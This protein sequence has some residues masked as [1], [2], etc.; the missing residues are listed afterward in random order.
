M[1]D[2]TTD[3]AVKAFLGKFDSDKEA[4]EVYGKLLDQYKQELKTISTIKSDEA[5]QRRAS[6][7]KDISNIQKSL[8]RL[9]KG[10]AVAGGLVAGGIDL[11]A[12]PG[13]IAVSAANFLADMNIPIPSEVAKREI[14]QEGLFFGN[15]QLP[16][17]RAETAETRPFFGFSRGAVQLPMRTPLGT[18]AQSA[19]Y[20][21]AGAADESGTATA[22]LGAGQVLAGIVQ[23][24]RGGITAY[25]ARQLVKDLPPNERNLL[26]NFMLR[27]QSGSDPQT[28]A[29]IQRLKAN[30]ET[31]E[32]MNA[33]EQGAKSI[34]LAGMAPIATEGKIA[35][36]AYNAI[37]QKLRTLQY[38]ISGKPISD[39]FERAKNIL[40]DS[41]SVPILTTLSRID[42]LIADFANKGTDSSKAA[43]AAL[44]R[45]KQS[46]MTPSTVGPA[47]P[48]TTVEK[49][50]G[51]LSS[52]GAK[53]AGE[54]N[55]LKDVARSD[56]ERIAAVI[57]GGLKTDLATA[58][59]STNLDVRKAA[60]TLEDARKS[61]EKGYTAY[62]NFVAQGLPEKLRN[63]DL[64]QL[65]DVEFTKVF[66]G[67]TTDQRNRILPILEAQAP[68]AVDR[69]RLSYYNNFLQG[70][71]K[72]LPDGTFGIDF[73]KLVAKYNTLKPEDRELLSFSL[74][75]N[76]K[77]FAERMDDATKFFRYNMRIRAVPEEGQV[78]TGEQ[79]AK[80][81]AA[82]GAVTDYATAKAADVGLRLFNDL[83][84]NLKDTDVLR[85]LLTNEGKQFLK[86]AKLSPAG[87]KTL[88]NLEAFKLSQ[89]Q[90]P[91]GVLNL[92]R[93][94]QDFFAKQE[95]VLAEEPMGM[96]DA[97]IQPPPGM[98]GERAPMNVEGE[99]APMEEE[100]EFLIPPPR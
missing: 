32:L 73:E 70:A 72:R 23:G 30:P 3:E 84:S 78:L 14:G 15:L 96:D 12:L 79:V 89:T 76:S 6:L 7:Q 28:A 67:L 100:D 39:K 55:L 62:N 57:F 94:S 19:G 45:T 99:E 5:K 16:V 9:G 64:N 48:F 65:D 1:A 40:G 2:I 91:S 25:R 49:I 75:T 33:L 24:A 36:P 74:G 46:L 38:N 37:Q 85:L 44:Q 18:V 22:A 86:Q 58:T 69:L 42:G 90:L 50:Q 34:T 11:M 83:S 63:V 26:N 97:L 88:E 87:T 93:A 4:R 53:A 60:I 20:G 98:E 54:E 77:E 82:V 21:T 66:K 35:A 8:N 51:N 59:K 61:V 27:G 71:D 95:P 29:L 56:Q 80:G 31:A 47:S 10:K 92:S 81:Q 43:V 68:E 41:P 17:E 13:D 52:F